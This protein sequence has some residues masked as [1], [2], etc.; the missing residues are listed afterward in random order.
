MSL[1]IFSITA[2][3]LEMLN[4]SAPG[5]KKCRA[6]HATHPAFR[7]LLS[8]ENDHPLVGLVAIL[9]EALE[10]FNT[11]AVVKDI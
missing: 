9:Y 7:E 4:R 3:P 11:F 10:L 2:P 6:D 5:N 8:L 1:G